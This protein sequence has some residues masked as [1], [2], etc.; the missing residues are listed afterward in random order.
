MA[1]AIVQARMGSTRLPGKVLEDLDGAPLLRVLLDRARAARTIDD[2]LVACPDEAIDDRLADAVR[3]WGCRVVRGPLDDVLGRY[4]LAAAEV[5]DDLIVRLTGDCPLVDP[6]VIDQ[7]VGLVTSDPACRYARTGDG[8]P[9]GV[10]VEVIRRDALEELGTMELTSVER[11]HVTLGVVSHPDRFPSAVLRAVPDHSSVRITVDRAEDLE[12]VCEL[13]RR[14]GRGAEVGWRAYVAELVA[15]PDLRAT[16][17]FID[18]GEGLW[19]SRYLHASA[20]I[21]PSTDRTESARLLARARRV[22]PHATQTMSKAIDQFVEGVSPAFLTRGLGC[23]VW[24]PDGNAY[25]DYPMALGPIIL[26]YGHPSV[27]AA[28][29]AQLQDGPTFTLPHPLEAE[30]AE[31]LCD[32]VPCAE[33]ARF[34]KSGS[35]VT[36]AAVRLARA[37]TGRDRVLASGYH[38]W[39]DWYVGL[40]ELRR[41]VPDEVAALTERLPVDSVEALERAVAAGEPPAAL[42]IEVGPEGIA[43]DVLR[44]VREICDRTGAVF[45]W[46]EIVT[47]FRW[48]PGGAQQYFGVTPDLTCLGKAMANGMPVAALVGRHDLMSELQTVFFSGTFG[49]EAISLAAARATIDTIERHRVCDHIWDIGRRLRD[50]LSDL[51]AAHD[52]EIELRGE[53]PRS[54]LRFLRHGQLSNELR[55]LFLQETVRRG[56]LFGGPIFVTLAHEEPHI[57]MTLQV[58]ADALEVLQKAVDEDAVAE[59]LDGPPPGSVFKPVR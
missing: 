16:N 44:A 7:V 2:I 19:R 8:F 21:V 25:V 30:V 47:G 4:L 11:E 9:D 5:A 24:D 38:G 37:V 59:R 55:G 28:C 18:A 35:D 43:D 12:V 6:A 22:I 42:V 53:P 14:C 50:G 29:R 56:V 51:I 3:S 31:R 45:V 20:E 58:C 46:D 32:V 13:V 26:G 23:Q 57:D 15:D 10:D 39:H 49:G 34:A 54:E 27:L 36:S 1:S 48:A 41:G 52:L 17:S 40:T 33:M